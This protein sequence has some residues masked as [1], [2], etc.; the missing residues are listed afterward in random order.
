MLFFLLVRH[1]TTVPELK[2][3]TSPQIDLYNIYKLRQ[4]QRQLTFEYGR[5]ST[6]GVLVKTGAISDC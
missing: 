4:R 2:K 6:V 3:H 1:S 5:S